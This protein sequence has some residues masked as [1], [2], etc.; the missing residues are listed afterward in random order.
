MKENPLR[1]F[2]AI[3][4]SQLKQ[5][6]VKSPYRAESRFSKPKVHKSVME[7]N[8]FVGVLDVFEA[9]PNFYV[10]HL[11]ADEH[12]E[13]PV[14]MN[15]EMQIYGRVRVTGRWQNHHKYGDQFQIDTC[16]LED[17]GPGAERM[18]QE[19]WL[20]AGALPILGA[21][22]VIGAAFFKLYKKS[23]D[24]FMRLNEQDLQAVKG[25]GPK[26]VKPIMK[27]WDKYRDQAQYVATGLSLGL[28]IV[29]SK[30]AFENWGADMGNVIRREPYRLIAI[31]INFKRADHIAMAGGHPRKSR[32]RYLYSTLWI[33]K[34]ATRNG[35]C[36]LPV[37]QVEGLEHF[38][39]NFAWPLV[40]ELL[41]RDTDQLYWRDMLL[42]AEGDGDSPI[43]IL[44]TETEGIIYLA[45]KELRQQQ[46][47]IAED[48][49]RIGKSYNHR[50][51]K[52]LTP[53]TLGVRDLDTLIDEL[54]DPLVLA[55]EQRDAVKLACGS[56]LMVL[57]GGPGT[58]KTTV[59]NTILKVFDWAG[60]SV[61]CAAPT[62]KAAMRM[63]EA[64]G[65]RA[66]TVHRLLDWKGMFLFNRK[67]QLQ[68]QA[69]VVDETSML[70]TK[71]AWALLQAIKDGVRL[72]L[73]GDPDQL[74]AVG[75]GQV[76]RDILASECV[77][78]IT[79]SKIHRQAAGSGIVQLA[80]ALRDARPW[81]V[82]GYDDLLWVNTTSDEAG[83]NQIKGIMLEVLGNGFDLQDAMV[84]APY[85]RDCGWLN[86]AL[87]SLFSAHT[88][89]VKFGKHITLA[90][91]DPVIH[92]RNNYELEVFNGETGVVTSLMNKEEVKDWYE[93]H[94]KM[95]PPPECVVE[96]PD[97]MG[98]TREVAYQRGVVTS[99]LRLAYSITIHK[100]QGSEFPLTVMFL[101]YRKN[102]TFFVRELV[103]TAIT[104]AKKKLV[105]VGDRRMEGVLSQAEAQA[106]RWTEL[107]KF[108]QEVTDA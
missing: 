14:K 26:N 50:D 64:T 31:G 5:E 93:K 73:V 103:Y 37:M 99:E 6:K 89:T 45:D 62:G 86:N 33:L 17:T 28:T 78:Y 34:E 36:G 100:S 65:V 21:N 84:L 71:I 18:A 67:N 55:E 53:E 12:G 54:S 95:D 90:I 68:A 20:R 101:P 24:L 19:M 42:E 1:T 75:P 70:D 85:N 7:C 74:P 30:R 76:L 77:P 102:L 16:Q 108:I 11:V 46:Q 13:I 63:A 2:E 69:V 59:L 8:R 52:R 43:E 29:E 15:H 48:L 4:G 87:Q 25:I 38:R 23:S 72:V 44:R 22:G 104:R 82:E 107:A 32:D 97:P 3:T 83:Y 57:T 35:H 10:G 66:Q 40:R 96:Y 51:F 9:A 98:G 61:A 58:G 56:S 81:M 79:L 92:T 27:A 39:K 60:L 41:G 106:F 105:I 91:G 94:G 49:R 80:T 88:K 47:E